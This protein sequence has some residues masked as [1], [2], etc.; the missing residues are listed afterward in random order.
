MQAPEPPKE[1]L[2]GELGNQARQVCLIGASVRSAAES[3][4]RAGYEVFAVDRYGDRDTLAVCRRHILLPDLEQNKIADFEG[5]LAE[6]AVWV[7]SMPFLIVGGMKSAH[8]LLDALPLNERDLSQ[9]RSRRNA[10]TLEVLRRACDETD[11]DFPPTRGMNEFLSKPNQFP[12]SERGES[13]LIK[14][15]DYCGGLGVRWVNGED[16]TRQPEEFASGYLQ[17]WI[18]GRL[19]GT[20]LLSNGLEVAVIGTCRGRFTRRGSLPF[21]YCGSVGPVPIETSTHQAILEVGKRLVRET[22]FRGIFNLDWI[23]ADSGQ[24]WLIEINPRWSAAVELLE[25]AWNEQIAVTR[26]MT[27]RTS[28]MHW[29]LSALNGCPLSSLMGLSSSSVDPRLHATSAGS[30]YKRV[31][32]S[33][34]TRLFDPQCLRIQLQSGESLHDLPSRPVELNAGDPICTLIGPWRA[35]EIEQARQR[36]RQLVVEIARGHSLT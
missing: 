29:V 30:F 17:K 19:Y 36:Y 26:E 1:P 24:K 9:E 16:L 12:F 11:F 23:Q 35:G 6:V 33:K 25:R 32:F 20:S 3:A 18:P 15:P 13:W 21:V 7:R 31:V 27:S 34:Q 22:G 8:R 2:T 10:R 4:K 5:F 14:K 28:M